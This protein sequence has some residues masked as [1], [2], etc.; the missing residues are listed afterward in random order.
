MFIAYHHSVRLT[1]HLPAVVQLIRIE[2]QGAY[3]GLVSGRPS[4][5][6]SS[7][8]ELEADNEPSTSGRV[9]EDRFNVDRRLQPMD[10]RFVKELVAGGSIARS[11][12]FRPCTGVTDRVNAT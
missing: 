2:Q 10:Q 1:S 12:F 7:N 6:S 11:N 8:D 5:E 9:M 3:A 4:L